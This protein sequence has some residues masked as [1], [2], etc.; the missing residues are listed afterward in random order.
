MELP[1]G[2]RTDAV[3][4]ELTT[5]GVGGPLGHLWPVEHAQDVRNALQFAQEHGLP[6]WVLGGGS[7]VVVADDGL[8][9]VVVQPA[10]AL[11]C[12]IEP[13]EVTAE[14]AVVR[15]RAGVTWDAL[16]A[17]AVNNGWQ[18]VECL[19]GIPGQVGAAPIQNIGAYGQEF[20]EV[21]LA[22]H[23]IDTASLATVRLDA[24][25]CRFA[26]RDS[27]FKAQPGRWVVLGVDL[28]LRPTG[29][30]CVRYAQVAEAVAQAGPP[31]LA[32]VREVVLGLRRAKGMVVEAND[33]DSRS[34]GSFFVN[35]VMAAPVA[36][37]VLAALA[38]PGET[39]PQ[40]PQV[41]GSVKLS[42]AWLIERAGMCKGFGAGRVG[43]SSKHTLAVVNRGGATAAEVL[44]FADEVAARVH[45]CC[46]V[47]LEREPVLLRPVTM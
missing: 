2:V 8:P 4:R 9:G 12:G 33:P 22:V 15:V 14:A 30:P 43:L 17:F 26:Y 45:G 28:A 7:N 35:P 39:P 16:V 42:A 32:Q 3:G 31:T 24:A 19:S 46:G 29:S 36:T 23:A 44:A 34:C 37:N 10:V 13:L 5:I 11:G 40:W 47:P 1:H 27:V 6:W 38:T 41:D 20:A 21:A 18:G 25:A